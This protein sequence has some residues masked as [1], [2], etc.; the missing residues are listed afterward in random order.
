MKSI[1]TFTESTIGKS[2]GNFAYNRKLLKMPVTV[3][4]FAKF[5]EKKLATL[6]KYESFTD[7]LETLNLDNNTF[8]PEQLLLSNPSVY[9]A[10]E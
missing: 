8:F 10:G 1:L 5:P 7:V 2:S 3:L 9:Q 4:V 6:L